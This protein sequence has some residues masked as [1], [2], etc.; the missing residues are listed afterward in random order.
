MTADVDWAS[1]DSIQFFIDQM[2]E[3]GIRPMLFVTHASR[4]IKR[5]HSEGLIDVGIHPNFEPSSSQGESAEEII[6]YLLSVA[7][8]AMVTRSHRFSDKPENNIV[9]YEKGFR[10]DSNELRY[11]EAEIRPRMTS[12][13]HL[14]FPVYWSD[15]YALKLSRLH[16]AEAFSELSNNLHVPGLKILNVHP[17]NYSLNITSL[18]EYS[19]LKHLTKHASLGLI[20]QRNLDI[21]W[22]VKDV[23]DRFISE[24]S[25]SG[26]NFSSF[27]EI[28]QH[29]EQASR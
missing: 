20:H 21:T 28:I 6:D 24:I 18:E 26:L 15:G 14:R 27:T 19:S 1:E 23:M 13:G 16:L 7:P 29:R 10:F 2:M 17:F 3:L 9:L 22:G 12:T 5:Y 11:L 4:V 8:D 25:N